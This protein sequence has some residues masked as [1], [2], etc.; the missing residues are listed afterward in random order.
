MSKLSASYNL[1]F[2]VFN[3]YLNFCFSSKS[4]QFLGFH[5]KES[6]KKDNRKKD[7]VR[8]NQ[9][10]QSQFFDDEEDDEDD[11]FKSARDDNNENNFE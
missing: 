1:Q 11:Q 8:A 6:L 7:S 3:D 4:M 2:W 9:N 10:H 5:R